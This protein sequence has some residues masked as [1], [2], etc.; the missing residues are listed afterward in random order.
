MSEKLIYADELTNMAKE[1][2]AKIADLERQLAEAKERIFDGGRNHDGDT[3][4]LGSLCPWC[5]IERLKELVEIRTEKMHFYN[6]Q[7]EDA[8]AEIER[9]RKENER[10]KGR[11]GIQCMTCGKRFHAVEA[12]EAHQSE[13]GHYYTPPEPEKR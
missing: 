13:H 8:R 7:A 2:E 4:T 11:D 5:E 12:Y 1:Y 9:L 3:C 6:K 10:L